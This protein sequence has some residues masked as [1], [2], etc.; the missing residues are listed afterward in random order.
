MNYRSL[1]RWWPLGLALIL[2][3]CF[4]ETGVEEF[5]VVSTEA[6]EDN[7]ETLPT[8]RVAMARIG[9][10]VIKNSGIQ[11][12]LNGDFNS[13]ARDIFLPRTGGA[14]L[15]ISTQFRAGGSSEVLPRQDDGINLL[16]QGVNYNYQTF[17]SYV[18]ARIAQGDQLQT[19]L[20]LNGHI[21]DMDGSLQ[22]AGASVDS[23]T[24]RVLDATV[25]TTYELTDLIERENELQNDI[26]VQ[27]VDATTVITN[28]GSGPLAIHAV[29]DIVLTSANSM[30]TF[31]PYPDWGY[32]QP[33]EDATAW[34][35]FAIMQPRTLNTAQYGFFS[36]LDGVI[37]VKT[38]HM[39]EKN[40]DVLYVGKATGVSDTLGSGETV[41]FN[42]QIMAS[43]TGTDVNSGISSALTYNFIAR[44]LNHFPAA[45][46]VFEG[47]LGGIS[48]GANT[49]GSPGGTI[50]LEYYDQS[51]RYFNGQE[52][53]TLEE[54]RS[55]PIFGDIRLNTSYQ[56][57]SGP[58]D[59]LEQHLPLGKV[60]FQVKAL[61]SEPTT[62][63][64]AINLTPPDGEEPTEEFIPIEIRPDVLF[65]TGTFTVADRH[66][67]V[68]ITMTDR[69][70][71]GLLGRA[72]VDRT[73]D[74]GP[75]SNSSLP[76]LRQ[77]NMVYV[78]NPGTVNSPSVEF[79]VPPGTYDMRVA[80][81]PLHAASFS[82]FTIEARDDDDSTLATIV[83]PLTLDQV[84]PWEGYFSADFDVRSS[85]DPFGL[86]SDRN[87]IRMAAAEN[88]DVVFLAGSYNQSRIQQTLSIEAF[89]VQGFTQQENEDRVDGLFDEIAVSRATAVIGKVNDSVRDRGRFAVLNLPPVEEE[90]YLQP[91][92]FSEDPAT[93]F[94]AARQIDP[95]VLIHLTRPRAPKG[96]ETGYFN[97]IN[98]LA[99]LA[100]NT[101]LPADNAYFSQTAANG[102]ATTWLDFDLIELLPGN[103][104]DEYLLVRQDWF[105]LLNAGVF[106]PATGGSF[107]KETSDLPVGVVRAWVPVSD[108]TTRDNDLSEFWSVVREGKM[109]VS[110]GPLIEASVNGA[111][112]G[113]R[114]SV[115]GDTVTVNL[116][117]IAAP[118]IP[119]TEVRAVVNG[120]VTVLPI[121]LDPENV[122][123]F[124]GTVEISLPEGA[125]SHWL[126]IEAGATLSELATGQAETGAYGVI[127]PG[128]L[129][130]AFI[131]P[132]FL[133]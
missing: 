133:D 103:N 65:S 79:D 107:A 27:W 80:H 58:S 96:V 26:P 77:G 38:D 76:F 53:V 111:S 75:V 84:V 110:N 9:D 62:I 35:P 118:W 78:S 68:T 15:D 28:N 73:S 61:N 22:A 11:L 54:G 59:A 13:P 81:G 101:P 63:D 69:T 129:P 89:D 90:F 113:E 42:R 125:D 52:Y 8:G 67:L 126:V 24:R 30:A 93:F 117:V 116:N 16:T 119:V 1:I 98:E 87:L 25:T 46:S 40:Q 121:T 34:P 33:S 5:N 50:V 12:V 10:V 127:Y 94:D 124:D 32:E 7:G 41:T 72:V 95:D 4:R 47:V 97:V 106:K 49:V 60:R 64:A 92:L 131:N 88:I 122:N 36:L 115:S 48:F 86:V 102:S 2:V 3:S 123:R 105:N 71:R 39:A 104:Y 20:I 21:Y 55:L 57:F 43:N 44:I 74:E 19:L 6:T 99:G 83:V 108:T 85:C 37:K 109:L 132:I 120:Q 91:P 100:P 66:S 56:F 18:D 82:N 114:T 29:N 130:L 128:H 23:A 14:V 45:G 70:G 51:T 31:V 112:M 17:I